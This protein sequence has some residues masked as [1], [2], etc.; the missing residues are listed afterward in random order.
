MNTLVILVLGSRSWPQDYVWVILPTALFLSGLIMEDVKIGYFALIG[1]ATL[2]F[3]LNTYPVFPY[4]LNFTLTMIPI[5]LIGN[6]LM[7]SGLVLY[8]LRH[9]AIL[10][11]RH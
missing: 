3:N 5:A 6:F 8:Y 4:Y 2:L 10:N 11:G 7:L 1:V 9:N